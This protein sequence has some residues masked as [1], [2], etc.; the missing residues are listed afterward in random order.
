MHMFYN[1]IDRK[2][3]FNTLCRLEGDFVLWET[4]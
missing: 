2:I 3:L 4:G 1:T